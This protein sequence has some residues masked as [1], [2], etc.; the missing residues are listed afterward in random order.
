MADYYVCMYSV[1]LPECGGFPPFW[2]I[3]TYVCI[4]F[5]CGGFPP[6]WPIIITYVENNLSTYVRRF[7]K[8]KICITVE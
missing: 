5:E 6:F 1:C 8:E 3:I 7:R 2:P 4:L